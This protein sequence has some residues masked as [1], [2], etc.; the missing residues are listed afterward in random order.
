[1][2]LVETADLP[3]DQQE[4]RELQLLAALQDWSAAADTA[5]YVAKDEGLA[6]RRA[7]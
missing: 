6:V 5:A 7:R 4:A 3:P 2:A 1:M